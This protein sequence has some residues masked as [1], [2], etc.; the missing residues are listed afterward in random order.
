MYFMLI[1]NVFEAILRIAHPMTPGVNMVFEVEIVYMLWN[2]CQ[3]FCKR[4][5]F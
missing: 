4:I 1:Y 5:Q 3:Q 2:I